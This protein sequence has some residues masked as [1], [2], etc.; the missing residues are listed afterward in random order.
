MMD[1]VPDADAMDWEPLS[2]NAGSAPLPPNRS[3]S[4]AEDDGW[5]RPQRFFPPERPTGLEGLFERTRLEDDRMAATSRSRTE[6]HSNVWFRTRK[7]MLVLIPI[8]IAGMAIAWVV[9]HR[10]A[11]RLVEDVFPTVSV[12]EIQDDF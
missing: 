1:V 10:P 6:S 7:V 3:Q 12:E 11:A 5:L 2:A 9:Y 4:Q 8:V